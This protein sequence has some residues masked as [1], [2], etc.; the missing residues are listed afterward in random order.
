M[1]GSHTNFSIYILQLAV[2]ALL[3]VFLSC[4]SNHKP[5]LTIAT[6]ANAQFAIEDIARE[7]NKEMGI[8]SHIIIG[9]S[10]KHTAQIEAGAPYDVFISADLKFPATLYEL[11]LTV[12]E[13]AIYA[14]G[15]IVIWTLKDSLNLDINN[16]MSAPLNHIAM[17]N[18]K[19][20]PYGLAAR[21]AL[22]YFNI[23]NTIRTKL[24]FGESVA[25]TNQFILSKSA[26]LG[27]T[28]ASIVMAPAMKNKGRWQEVDNNSYSP[29]AQAAVV[30]NQSTQP[31]IAHKFYLFLFSPKA[32]K[33]LQDHGYIVL[34]D[35]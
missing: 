4:Q 16:L 21:E 33:I 10:G 25:Q 14:Y 32:Q 28:A 12:S 35:H 29:I 23:Y 11:G 30:L 15:K 18:P 17:P 2:V 20:A 5:V 9:S 24:V 26:D 6:A 3:A 34:K 19:T 8:D 27:F 22:T 7:F 1:P 31:E 13:P